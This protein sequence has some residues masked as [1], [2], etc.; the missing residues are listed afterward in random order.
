[1]KANSVKVL[2]AADGIK[3]KYS[4]RNTKVEGNKIN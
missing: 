3:E 1:M 2:N 4:T